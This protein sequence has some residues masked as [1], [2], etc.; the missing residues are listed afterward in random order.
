MHEQAIRS[1]GLKAVGAA[2]LF[3][4]AWTFTVRPAQATLDDQRA[5]LQAQAALIE[6]HERQSLNASDAAAS[7]EELGR[8]VE[9]LAGSLARH[10]STPAILRTVE[11]LAADRGVRVHRTDPRS[12]PRSS[13]KRAKSDRPEIIED[14]LLVEFSGPFGPVA[15]FLDDLACSAGVAHLSE[16]RMAPSVDGVHGTVM[17]T[18]FRTPP[19][20]PLLPPQEE[21]P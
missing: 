20:Q 1:V 10:E 12:A 18:V 7:L 11:S 9:R 15:A 21:A 19:D 14:G 13:G 17:M 5:L 2:V 16:L 4:V 3:G 8:R 6:Q